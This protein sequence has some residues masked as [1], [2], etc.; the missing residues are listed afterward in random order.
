MYLLVVSFELLFMFPP[1]LVVDEPPLVVEI[2]ALVEIDEVEIIPVET[3]APLVTKKLETTE[4]VTG[5]L[6]IAPV[7]ELL[8]PVEATPVEIIPV[9]IVFV[10]M[11]PEVATALP[12]VTK[13]VVGIT[14]T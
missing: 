5:E 11:D 4:L 12:V 13:P 1:S 10:V 7:V 14:A 3:A 2:T 8:P 9:E 6:E